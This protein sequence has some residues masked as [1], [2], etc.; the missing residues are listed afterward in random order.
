[1][2]YKDPYQHHGRLCVL[3]SIYDQLPKLDVAGSSPVSSSL[4]TKNFMGRRLR[5]RRS[6]RAPFP[7]ASPLPI[8]LRPPERP[9]RSSAKGVAVIA[10]ALV[11]SRQA[12]QSR[13]S[14]L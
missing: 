2:C 11:D 3:F 14:T 5:I 6:S 12:L 4:K 8:Q 13:I 10:T 7:D 9:G 1:M